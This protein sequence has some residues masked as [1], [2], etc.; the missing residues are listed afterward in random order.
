MLCIDASCRNAD[1]SQWV[2][3]ETGFLTVLLASLSQ[4][5]IETSVPVLITIVGS[6]GRKRRESTGRVIT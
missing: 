2:E 5:S 1:I 4:F 3:G 6:S